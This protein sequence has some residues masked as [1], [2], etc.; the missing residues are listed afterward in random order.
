M[1]VSSG[2]YISPD[3]YFSYSQ[4]MVFDASVKL[5]GCDW[6]DAHISQGF[7]RRHGV[8]AVST[9]LEFGTARVAVTL[10]AP[11]PHSLQAYT[12]VIAVPLA[13]T[14]GTLSIQGPEEDAGTRQVRV[15]K[16]HYRATIAQVVRDAEHGDDEDE[17]EDIRIWFEKV[18]VPVMRSRLLVMDDGLDPP[19]PLVETADI[20]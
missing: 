13:V 15:A 11:D 3:L 19:T 8:V 12:R 17:K 1:N 18:D 2:D 10:A 20:A 6:T 14:S 4:F 7:A 16:G 9:L 5:P